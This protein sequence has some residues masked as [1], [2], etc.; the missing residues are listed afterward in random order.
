MNDDEFGYYILL[1][2]LSCVFGMVF[3]WT[4]GYCF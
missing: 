3:G 2:F 4:L 1:V